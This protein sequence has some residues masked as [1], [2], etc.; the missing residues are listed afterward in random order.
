MNTDHLLQEF[1]PVS[2]ESWEEL[3]RKDLKGADY[4]AKLIWQTEEG[5]AVKPYY[6]AEDVAG[7]KYADAQPGDFPM[8]AALVQPAIGAFAKKSMLLD[9][10]E[11]NRAAHAAVLA[12]AGEIAF[13]A[14]SFKNVADLN[15]LLGNLDEIPVHF[16][17]A[18]EPQLRLLIERLNAQPRPAPVSTGWNPLANLDFAA[19]VIA[20][21]PASARPLHYPW[22]RV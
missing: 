15:S 13:V 7:L 22:R 4:A 3:I 17:N 20:A 11:A 6:R 9:C 8:R 19:E 14:A 12:G 18:G 10:E 2:T 16:E 21:A 5:L 1:P